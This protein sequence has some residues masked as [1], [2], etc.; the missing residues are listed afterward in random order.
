[1]G[2][3]GALLFELQINAHGKY[4]D[5][6]DCVERFQSSYADDDNS[7]ST[8]SKW[9]DVNTIVSFLVTTVRFS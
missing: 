8:N 4:G 1:M 6:K 5:P 3:L 9:I 7:K 2:R